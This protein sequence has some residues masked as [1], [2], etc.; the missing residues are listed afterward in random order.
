MLFGRQVVVQIGER[1]KE[2][3]SWGGL[4]VTFRIKHTS[5][6]TPNEATLEVYNWG[7]EAVEQLRADG[8]VVRLLAGYE[9]PRLLF[10]GTPTPDGVTQTDD[11]GDVVTKVQ[12]TDGGRELTGGQ[13]NLSFG[14]PTTVDQLLSAAADEL[15]LPE[16]QIDIPNNPRLEQ[17]ATLSGPVRDVLD[18]ISEMAGAQW[19]IQ[20]GKLRL[21]EDEDTG[22]EVAEY[23][24]EAGTLIGSP[25]K[26]DE[27]LKVRTLLDPDQRPGHRFKLDHDKHGGLWRARQVVFDGDSWGGNFYSDIKAT[28]A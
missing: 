15:G 9:A 22:R 3:S 18:R 24:S 11:G 10:V 20:D 19:S 1:G 16:G 27:G 17:G 12:A 8:T 23:S 21:L 4:R 13:L 5:S 14:T 28:P 7:D 2:G 6:G 25:E 26:L